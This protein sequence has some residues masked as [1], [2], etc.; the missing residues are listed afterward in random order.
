MKKLLWDEMQ[1][2]RAQGL[3]FNCDKKFTAG[4]RYRG[5]QLLLLEGYE[6]YDEEDNPEGAEDFTPEISLHAL[7]GWTTQR[8]MR[9]LAKIGS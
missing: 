2:R 5:P 7:S 4:H 8:T 3:C 1:K 9:V 6:E